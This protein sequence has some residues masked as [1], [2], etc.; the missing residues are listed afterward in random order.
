MWGWDVREGSGGT[1]GEWGVRMT[2]ELLTSQEHKVIA[3]AAQ[4]WND[5]CDIVGDG[6]SR[7]AD[8]QEFYMSIHAIQRGVMKQAAARAYPDKYRLLGEVIK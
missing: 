3:D 2:E 6:D 8:L 7:D 1:S 4:L 5:L